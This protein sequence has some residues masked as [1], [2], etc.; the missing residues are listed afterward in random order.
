MTGP[1]RFSGG[2]TTRRLTEGLEED[3]LAKFNDQTACLVITSSG[4][5]ELAVLNIDLGSTTFPK[6]AA[7]VPFV[8][9]LVEHLLGHSRTQNEFAS[10]EPMAVYLPFEAGNADGLTVS[11]I[12]P[13]TEPMGEFAPEGS[14]VLWRAAATGK[15]GVYQAKRGEQTVFMVSTAA[16]AEEADLRPLEEEVFR[17]RLAGG[18]SLRFHSSVG[19]SQE[20]DDHLW[21]WAA[22]ACLACLLG[23]VLG[24]RLLRT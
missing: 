22:V 4:S 15:P 7:F 23:E 17:K 8:G 21:V 14:S 6:T 18:R 1:L 13:R 2:L 3:I 20:R 5:C 24:L 19:A 11:A 16:P 12:S 10:G 9:E